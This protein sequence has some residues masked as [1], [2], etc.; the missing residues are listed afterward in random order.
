MLISSMKTQSGFEMLFTQ[1]ENGNLEAFEYFYVWV[2]LF[3][4][5]LFGFFFWVNSFQISS[6]LWIGNRKLRDSTLFISGKDETF[7]FG[8]SVD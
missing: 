2:F 4:L 1:S 3:L 8:D 7:H 6:P 5:I